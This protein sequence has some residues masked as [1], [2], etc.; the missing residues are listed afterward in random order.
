MQKRKLLCWLLVAAMT[1]SIL[2]VPAS[3]DPSEPAEA[4][5]PFVFVHGLFGWGERADMNKLVPYWGLMTGDLMKYLN[6]RGYECYSATVGPLSSAWDRACEL[7]AQLT[8][9]TV[10]Y[11]IAHSAEKG[12]D[13][14]G[15]TYDEPMF[16]GWGAEKKINLIGHSFG[17]ATIRMFLELL[18][19]G[20]QAEVKAA[21]DAGLEVSPLF[22]GGK[23]DWVYSLTAVSAP[24]NGTSFIEACG[25]STAVVTDLLYN[26]ASVLSVTELKGIYDLQL[27]HFGITPMEGECDIDFVS[28]VLCSNEFLSHNDNAIYDLMIDNA[29]AI[30]DG[31]EMQ[32]GVYYFSVY[33]DTT[34]KNVIT[35]FEDPDPSTLLLLVPYA[36][37]MGR[38]YGR[39]TEGG[40]YIDKTWLPNDGMVNVQSGMFPYGS[41]KQCLKADGSQAYVICDG[42]TKDFEKGV[43]NV[44][45]SQPYDHLSIIGGILSNDANNV[46]ILFL[47]L[48]DNV[49]RTYSD[50]GVQ[51]LPS[52]LPFSLRFADRFCQ[53]L[54]FTGRTVSFFIAKLQ[55]I[56]SAGSVVRVR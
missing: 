23:A 40:F 38:Y 15:I 10:D 26:L 28:R 36:A 21:K 56:I 19:N 33:G 39:S 25:L 37:L 3:A 52:R 41:D 9:T 35:G 42:E 17:G 46:R 1:V 2:V 54:A 29:L 14:F 34:H 12:H 43:W 11:G 31:I 24:H 32:D 22:V 20:C 48:I 27:E 51:C 7:Y 49:I 4:D 8:G 16:E 45:P 13:R 50:S 6:D 18:A 53:L 44:L 5:Y 55:N 47:D 30:N